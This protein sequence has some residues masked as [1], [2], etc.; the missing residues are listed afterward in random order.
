MRAELSEGKVTLYWDDFAEQSVDPVTGKRD[1][2]GY[3]VYRSDLGA[4]RTGDLFSNVSLVAQYDKAGNRTGYNN[5]FGAVRLAQPLTF[6]GDPT[7]YSYRFEADGLLSGW[8][9]A[10]A[11]TAF[12]EGEALT[13]LPPFE[14]SLLANAVRVFPGAPAQPSEG[15]AKAGVYPNPYR[16]NAA[17]DGTTNR[18]RKLYFTNLPAKCEISVFTPAGELVDR[19]AHDAATSV[20]DTRWYTDFSGPNRVAA[21]GEHAWDLLSQANLNLATGLYL[22]TVRDTDTGHVQTGRFV[23]IK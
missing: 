8:Q 20:G 6:D 18:T 7:R 1:F 3:R 14:S 11:V 16:V 15:G 10:F 9:Y 2:E 21:G 17:W 13:G 5:G 19:F 22:F 23:I 4:D 12:D